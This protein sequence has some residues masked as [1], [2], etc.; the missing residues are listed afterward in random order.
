M[1]GGGGGNEGACGLDSLR[2]HRDLKQPLKAASTTEA[3]SEF[4]SLMVLWV[5][6]FDKLLVEALLV[7]FSFFQQQQLQY[8]L[9][10]C[11]TL[12]LEQLIYDFEMNFQRLIFFCEFGLS[13]VSLTSTK[14]CRN[15]LSLDQCCQA[16][17]GPRPVQLP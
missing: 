1:G 3:G 10:V 13:K 16:W 9:F 2:P 8:I 11:L 15:S 7:Y 17:A 12:N 6:K 14:C 5:T 4:Q